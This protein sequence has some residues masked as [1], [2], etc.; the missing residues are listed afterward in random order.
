MQEKGRS[1]G[2]IAG[3]TAGLPAKSALEKV[4]KGEQCGHSDQP[5]PIL[6]LEAGKGVVIEKKCRYLFPHA[7]TRL[8]EK[9]HRA[10][11]GGLQVLER[12]SGRIGRSVV[13]AN[14]SC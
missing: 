9:A 4:A 11:S 8:K 3:R 13:A 1:V 14:P 12:G 5:H 2:G 7:A 6:E 10:R